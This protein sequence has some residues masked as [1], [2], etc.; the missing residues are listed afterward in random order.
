MHRRAALSR[1]GGEGAITTLRCA[2]LSLAARASDAIRLTLHVEQLDFED[3]RRIRRDDAGGAAGAVAELG[4]DDE[5]AL[6]ADLH[7]GHAFIP[8]RDDALHPDRKFERPAAVK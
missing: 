3:Q 7:C 8:A 5:R 6:A 4:R 1:V 2:A